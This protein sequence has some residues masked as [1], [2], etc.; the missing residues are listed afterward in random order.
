MLTWMLYAMA[1]AAVMSL[2]AALLER[3]VARAAATRLLWI[4]TLIA[5]AGWAMVAAARS[6]TDASATPNIVRD[7]GTGSL[8]GKRSPNATRSTNDASSGATASAPKSDGSGLDLLLLGFW[9]VS[10]GACLTVLAV[11]AW[12]IER[13]R[14]AWH[15]RL[16][17][18]VP[19]LISHD[20][21]PA[22]VGLVHHCI[23]VP[24]W[25]ETLDE[26]QQQIVMTHE[27]EH[28]R[29]GDPLLL[30]SA[31][32]LVAL[33]PW[34]V[35]LW[36]AL[37]RLRHA[38][39]LDCDARV[40][41]SRSSAHEYCEL[42][43]DVGERTLAGV[44]P[45]AALAE[46]AT[47]LE[48]R[49]EAMMTTRTLGWRSGSSAVMGAALIAVACYA[50]KPVLTPRARVSA[51]V[52]ELTA[53]LGTDAGRRAMTDAERTRL[54]E[55]LHSNAIDSSSIEFGARTDSIGRE[56]YPAAFAPHEDAAIVGAI[57]A[58]DGKL[59][60]TFM[61]RVPLTSAFDVSHMGGTTRLNSRDSKML[62]E[63]ATD[64][65]MGEIRQAGSQTM[66]SS[67]HT[68]IVYAVLLK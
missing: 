12:R 67:P 46:P 34:N 58:A 27:R 52:S 68:V 6:S 45:I 33:M 56:R 15:E 44:A 13:M 21:G 61:K 39:E 54:A 49:I 5:S 42:L 2:A 55:A 30:W 7:A 66:W 3:V 14:R 28:V 60:R 8:P 17:A 18:G 9:I 62:V 47:L 1:L 19:V 41:R 43:L 31:T 64:E 23:V 53:L 48:R 37:R 50:P 11:S 40:L 36:Y 35:P 22:V 59:V 4:A 25:V 16:V 26:R 57:Y 29:A 20:I 32:L 38:I 63:L 51:A 10:S 65:E 24:A